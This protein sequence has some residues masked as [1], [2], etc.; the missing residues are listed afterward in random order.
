MFWSAVARTK[1]LR[2]QPWVT[3]IGSRNRPKLERMPKPT[4]AIRQPA[5][6]TT[7]G[8]LHREATG[9]GAV[10]PEPFDAVLDMSSSTISVGDLPVVRG[11]ATILVDT[12]VYLH[13]PAN[14][15]AE[16][17]GGK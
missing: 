1:R 6:I 7:S 12:L 9:R 15:S 3:V 8:V 4:M 2:S 14:K 5:R 10:G 16:G 17:R 13:G 11:S